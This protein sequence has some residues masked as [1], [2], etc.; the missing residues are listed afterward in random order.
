MEGMKLNRDEYRTIK[1]MSKEQMEN[2]LYNRN[3]LMYNSLRKEFESAY[4]DELD[5]SVQNFIT[6]IAYVLHFSDEVHL[7]QDELA[8]FMDDL[9]VSVDMFRKGEYKPEEYKEQLREDGIEIAKYDYDRLYREKDAPYKDICE[10]LIEFL[11][12]TKSRAKVVDDMKSILGMKE[13]GNDNQNM[14][15]KEEN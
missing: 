4:K 3:V 15:K 7:Q 9:F 13:Q 1:S 6:A 10:R 5:S 8:S 11:E 2:W 12:K 14:D